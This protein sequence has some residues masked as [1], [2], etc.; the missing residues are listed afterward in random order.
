M[1]LSS[2]LPSRLPSRLAVALTA[3][4]GLT[5]AGCADD[6]SGSDATIVYSPPVSGALPFLPIEVALANGYFEDEGLKVEKKETSPAA[7]PAAMSSGQ[8]DMSADVVYN[9]ARY[10]ESGVDVK[11]VAGLNDNVDFTLLRRPDVD[12]AEPGDGA[13]GWKETFASLKGLKI[14]TAGKGGPVGLTVAALLEQAGVKQGEFT[15]IDTPGPASVAALEGKQVDVVVSGGGFDT[16]LVANGLAEPVLT[17]GD[18]IAS[19]FGDQTN[20]ALVMTAAYLEDNPDA[21]EKIQ[22]AVATAME[23]ILDPAN[24]DDVIAIATES[25]TV[26]TDLLADRIAAYEYDAAIDVAGV[27]SAFEW[28]KS[29]EIITKDVDVSATIADGVETR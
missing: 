1:R 7:L 23:F 19:I 9:S 14:G 20:A 2:R 29:A 26:Q 18:G 24:I 15:L 10:V 27:E 21:A 13:D 8:V 16:P 6:A 11:Y 28:A 17:F 4:L 12:V 5:L 3:C 22:K 25:G